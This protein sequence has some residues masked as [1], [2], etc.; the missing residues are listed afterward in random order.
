M[1]K[2]V[3]P[4]SGLMIGL[5]FLLIFVFCYSETLA[6]LDNQEELEMILSACSEYC[7]KLSNASINFV[8]KERVVEEIYHYRP[9]TYF[10]NQPLPSDKKSS[11][12]V[13]E[14]RFT[15][16]GK[17]IEETRTLLEENGQKKRQENVRLKTAKLK[18]KLAILEPINLFSKDLLEHYQFKI[19]KEE[20]FKGRRAIVIEAKPTAQECDDYIARI[21]VSCSDFDILKIERE[22]KALGDSEWIKRISGE[23]ELEPRIIFITEFLHEKNGIRFPSRYYIKE[24]YYGKF[25]KVKG[26]KK[27]IRSETTV[28]YSNYRFHYRNFL[29]V[30]ASS[31]SQFPP[32]STN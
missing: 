9:G 3:F 12:F 23:W 16:K 2:Q 32:I 11:T 29:S 22:Q 10:S 15:L 18:D 13:Y 6:K 17:K 21:W 25:P 14:Y 5:L 20:K 26:K 28:S 19:V 1:R 4:S 7:E 30:L 24:A 27:I 8:C 31:L